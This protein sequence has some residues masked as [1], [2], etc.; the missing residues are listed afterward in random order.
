MV[1]CC[2]FFSPSLPLL[3]LLLPLLL[4]LVC[5]LLLVVFILVSLRV[6]HLLL[7][8]CFVVPLLIIVFMIFVF[9]L[10]LLLVIVV[11]LLLLLL[12]LFLLIV[13]HSSLDR[14]CSC[15]RYWSSWDS[16][17]DYAEIP[18]LRTDNLPFLRS[19]CG[20]QDSGDIL[21][22]RRLQMLNKRR[23]KEVSGAQTL[24]R[25]S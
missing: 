18:P 19:A 6:L 7:L 10:L 25:R 14:C 11:L 3:P 9:I 1:A 13:S 24:V 15:H 23:C 16:Y 17:C 8:L 4:L 21:Q 2:F 20:L 5:L 12:F 22:I